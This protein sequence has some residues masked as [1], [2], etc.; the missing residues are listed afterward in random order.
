MYKIK[1]D[2]NAK[3]ILDKIDYKITKRIFNKIESLGIEPRPFGSIKLKGENA[4]RIRLGNYRILYEIED[5]KK[6]I[7]VYHIAHRKDVYR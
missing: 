2:N 1:L 4:Y 5:K 7:I 3:K 6:E